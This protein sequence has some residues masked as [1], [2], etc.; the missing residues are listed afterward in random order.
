[1]K[2]SGWKGES[3]RHSL[4]RKGIKTNSVSQVR[5]DEETGIWF[6]SDGVVS[7]MV[8]LINLVGFDDLL[9]DNKASGITKEQYQADGS[10]IIVLPSEEA[11]KTV[12]WMMNEY[13]DG[14][15]KRKKQ[16]KR[17]LDIA[18]KEIDKRLRRQDHIE[19]RLD[20]HKSRKMFR[21]LQQEL[22]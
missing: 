13:I 2:G 16:I 9:K 6:E 7:D 11:E 17:M 3:R 22:N 12:R 21:D 10:N 20:L 1:M 5:I 14:D 4:A 15:R 18:I 8:S 19:I